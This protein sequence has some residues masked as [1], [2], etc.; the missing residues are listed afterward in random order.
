ML[1]FPIWQTWFGLRG[2][3]PPGSLPLL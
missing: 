1:Q 3:L 2:P